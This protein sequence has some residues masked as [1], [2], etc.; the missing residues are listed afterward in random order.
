M[1]LLFGIFVLF[2]QKV[3]NASVDIDNNMYYDYGEYDVQYVVDGIWDDGY[4]IRVIVTNKTNDNIDD[5]EMVFKSHDTIVNIW[6]ADVA[7]H[8]GNLYIIN[9][10]TWNQKIAPQESIVWVYRIIMGDIFL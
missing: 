5:W 6:N 10:N 8:E 2:P 4:N 1:N 3:V 7:C 9:N